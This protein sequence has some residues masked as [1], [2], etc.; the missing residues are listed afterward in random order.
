MRI[1]RDIHAS[2]CDQTCSA[3]SLPCVLRFRNDDSVL[4]KD[5]AVVGVDAGEFVENVFVI[6]GDDCVLGDI[7]N[8]V[9]LGV[10]SGTS[11][12]WL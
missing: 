3:E 8:L 7:F 2:R 6:R 10:G 4:V 12:S 9:G 5:G 11:E 1:C